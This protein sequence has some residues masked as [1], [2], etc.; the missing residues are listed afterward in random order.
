MYPQVEVSQNDTTPDKTYHDGLVDAYTRDIDR[1][2]RADREVRN[3]PDIRQQMTML[4][5]AVQKLLYDHAAQIGERTGQD[6]PWQVDDA[7]NDLLWMLLEFC[8]GSE[9]D[10]EARAENTR[11]HQLTTEFAQWHF[12][13]PPSPEEQ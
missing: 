8:I 4:V 5:P 11:A 1:A 6:C 9:F 3:D 2:A 7:A 13:W 10:R 12:D